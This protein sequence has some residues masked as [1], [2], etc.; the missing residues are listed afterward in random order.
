MLSLPA[1]RAL[2]YLQTVLMQCVV[3]LLVAHHYL[4][5]EMY[6]TAPSAYCHHAHQ[7]I[8]RT[9]LDHPG[10]SYNVTCLQMQVLYGL[11]KDLIA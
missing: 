11:L 3:T 10:N 2:W 8:M 7:A 4:L 6:D 9:H 1:I 5:A